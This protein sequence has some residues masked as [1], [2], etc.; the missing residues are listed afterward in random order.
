M[1]T[2]L[3]ILAAGK[4]VNQYPIL[5]PLV[6][7]VKRPHTGRLV[8]RMGTKRCVDYHAVE[9][10]PAKYAISAIR[11]K[12]RSRNQRGADGQSARPILDTV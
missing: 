6:G 11:R 2:K 8:Y 3:P 12:C 9:G 10:T 1:Q 7:L 4:S 5:I